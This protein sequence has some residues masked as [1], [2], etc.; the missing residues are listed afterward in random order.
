[1]FEH[2]VTFVPVQ[3]LRGKKEG[4]IFK[5]PGFPTQPDPESLWQ[6]PDFEKHFQQMGE[7]EWELVTAQPLLRGQYRAQGRLNTSYG[8]GFTITAGYYFFWK[9]IVE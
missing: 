8:L 7:E 9:R 4:V 1:M 5:R 3:Y 2:T 6:H